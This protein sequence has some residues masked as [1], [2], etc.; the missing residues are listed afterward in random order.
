MLIAFLLAA[1]PAA[2]PPL[3]EGARS[4]ANLASYLSHD[5]YPADAIRNEEQ[6][7]VGFELDVSPEGRVTAC[8][9]TS[10]S[11]SKSLDATTCR[12]MTER[13]R[14]VP[15]RDSK[16]RAVADVASASIRWVLPEDDGNSALRGSDDIWET[17]TAGDQRSCRRE[18][19]FEGGGLI[20][21]PVC[22]PIDRDLVRAAAEYLKAR[23]GDL[24]TVRLENR[25]VT[26]PLD[27]LPPHDESRGE[28]LVRGEGDYRLNEDRSVRDCSAGRF[29]ARFDWEPAPCFQTSF[30]DAVPPGTTNVRLSVQ[31]V[32]SRGP[33]R[34]RPAILP[35][36]VGPDGSVTAIAL[37]PPAK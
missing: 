16:G 21:V 23:P 12:I 22:M 34:Q 18:L 13:P 30:A 37:D 11:G 2:S 26:D 27:P 29:S 3:P 17:T 36:A 8:R 19:R 1:A 31:W 9:V 33:D 14:F 7:T 28:L 6:G 25:W 5:D 15:A 35:S 20:H 4:R 32:V 10:S 24:L